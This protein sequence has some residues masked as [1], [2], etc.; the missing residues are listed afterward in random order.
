M[1]ETI[2]WRKKNWIGHIMRGDGLMKEVMKGKMEDK[3]GPGRK[4]M[5]M[6]DDLLEKVPY[7]DLKR[8]AENRQDWRVWLPG[9][10]RMVEH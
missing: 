9:T 7:G 5:S 2:V 1:L 4:R 8:R 3:R 10:C 6:I